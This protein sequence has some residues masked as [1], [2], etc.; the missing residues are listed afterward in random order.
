MP[1]YSVEGKLGTG[2]T[3]FAVY[4]AQLALFTGR[5]VASNVDIKPEVL[6]PYKRCTY[7]RIPDKPTADDLHAMGHGNPDTYNEDRNGVLILDE[8]GT[9]LNTRSFQ[10]KGRAAVIDWMIHARKYG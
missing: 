1:V 2:K 7:V 8:L 9:W 6:H 3:K 4:Q 10:D 5:R